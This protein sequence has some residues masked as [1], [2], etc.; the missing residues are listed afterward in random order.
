MKAPPAPALAVLWTAP[1]VRATATPGS[2]T[3]AALTAPEMAWVRTRARATPVT[4]PV[5]A[6][7]TGAASAAL[8]PCLAAE[9]R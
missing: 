3:P 4:S 7:S 2:P 5:T 1:P 8:Y 6:T 9:S